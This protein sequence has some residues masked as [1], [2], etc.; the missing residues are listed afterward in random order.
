M[1][2]TFNG[3]PSNFRVGNMR[4]LI[5][6]L[7]ATTSTPESATKANPCVVADTIHGY[8]SAGD[9]VRIR[10]T[11]FVQMTE[12]NNRDF[13]AEVIDANSY[14][15]IG[16]DSTNYGTAESTGGTATLYTETDL[17]YTEPG[18]TLTLGRTW[19][20]RTAD[21]DGG[22]ALDKLNVGESC[23]LNL[24]M[25]EITAAKLAQAYPGATLTGTQRIAGGGLLAATVSAYDNA[26]LLILHPLNK[27]DNVASGEWRI[28]K[29]YP[30]DIGAVPMDHSQDQ[31]VPVTF[32]GL[33]DRDRARGARTWT[34]FN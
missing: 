33:P 1:A 7:S 29:A 5:C 20:D 18:S 30:T 17:G 6:E 9:L 11:G 13:L 19:R 16:E 15:L 2:T 24:T 25:K 4:A 8:G 27:A 21:Q 3:D 22:T 28:H 14:L 12:L 31:V 32:E 34:F 23:V 26:R 10:I